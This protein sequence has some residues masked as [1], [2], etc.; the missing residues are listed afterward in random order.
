MQTKIGELKRSIAESF[1]RIGDYLTL[2]NALGYTDFNSDAERFF[3]DILNVTY[4]CALRELNVEKPNFPA[5]DLA[6]D[7]KRKCFQVTTSGTNDKFKETLRIYK[8]YEFH[9]KYDTLNFLILSTVD[10][11]TATDKDVATRVINLSDLLKDI[12]S[13]ADEDIIYLEG[14][15]KE[16]LRQRDNTDSSPKHGITYILRKAE[17][18]KRW[19]DLDA[20]DENVLSSDLK[21]FATALSDLTNDQRSY[22]HFLVTK[23]HFPSRGWNGDSIYM[24]TD[25]AREHYGDQG[26]RLFNSLKAMD[27]VRLD[28]DYDQ[29][30]DERYV[31]AIVLASHGMLSD[32]DLF[33]E[34]RKFTGNNPERMRR[35][36][37]NCDFSCLD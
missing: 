28:D 32:F 4:N 3:I 9:K 26:V 18:F 16:Y 37:I 25:L 6:D 33:G 22:I 12:S 19:A 17:R 27:L 23:G 15:I 34:L 36:F 21:S 14:Y 5:I 31:T 7:R 2:T 8:N 29:H 11:V 24:P 35:I 13:L 10:R 1:V 20:E 30:G